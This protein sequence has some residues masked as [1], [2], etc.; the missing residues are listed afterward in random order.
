MGRKIFDITPPKSIER[1]VIKITKKKKPSFSPFLLTIILFLLAVPGLFLFSL[2]QSR[3]EV[4][5]VPKVKSWPFETEVKDFEGK[6]VKERKKILK[7]FSSTG[8][9]EKKEYAKGKIRIYNNSSVA[10]TLVK[11]T[12]FLS[13]NGKQFRITKQVTIPPKS[14]IDGVEVKADAPGKEYNIGPTKFSI[15]GLVGSNLYPLVYSESFEPMEGGFLGETHYVTKEDLEK[16]E[17]ELMKELSEKGKD[18]LKE[19]FSSDDYLI[20]DELIAQEVLEKSPLI[21]AGVEAETFFFKGEIETSALVF[22]KEELIKYLKDF[23]KGKIPQKEK[24]INLS[25]EKISLKEKNLEEKR[26]SFL[27]KFSLNTYSLPDFDFLKEKIK[28][29]LIVEG[30]YI[31]EKEPD[32]LSSQIKVYPFWIKQIPKNPNR[33]KIKSKLEF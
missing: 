5:V 28:N 9:K 32:I 11:R 6:L 3:A 30:E 15:P 22:K 24:I 27:V 19:K 10:V 16:A 4:E 8:V 17:K 7:E 26:A 20:F 33:I 2:W 13:S 23:T 29:K 25:L 31:L 1:K 18:S 21:K 12:R 14:F